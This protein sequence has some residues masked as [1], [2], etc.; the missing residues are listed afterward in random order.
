MTLINVLIQFISF[1]ILILQ[2]WTISHI[3]WTIIILDLI[4]KNLSFNQ[5]IYSIF[6]M[7]L[8]FSVICPPTSV[9]GATT[10]RNNDIT[11]NWDPSPESGVSYSVHSQEDG[12]PSANYSTSQTSHVLTGLQCGELYTLTVTASDTECSSVLSEP[13]Q[14]ETG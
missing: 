10:C 6:K 3:M 13:I 2:Y 12:G 8:L 14:T 1:T 9:T 11:V 7:S 5:F 4:S